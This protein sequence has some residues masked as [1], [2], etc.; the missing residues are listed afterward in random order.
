MVS[1]VVVKSSR[2]FTITEGCPDTFDQIVYIQ[3]K[4]DKLS[5]QGTRSIPMTSDTI[6]TNKNTK[7]ILNTQHDRKKTEDTMKHF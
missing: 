7:H 4:V 2:Q 1:A 6:R 5:E 3:D